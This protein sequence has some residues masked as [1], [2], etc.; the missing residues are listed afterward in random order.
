MKKEQDDAKQTAALRQSKE[1]I[2][3]LM[4]LLVGYLNIGL[5]IRYLILHQPD[6]E[7][8]Q[9]NYQLFFKNSLKL[10]GKYLQND[11]ALTRRFSNLLK[12]SDLDITAREKRNPKEVRERFLSLLERE[13]E[14]VID[15][16]IVI[17]SEAVRRRPSVTKGR[18]NGMPPGYG[19]QRNTGFTSPNQ[20]TRD[21]RP[22]SAMYGRLERPSSAKQMFPPPDARMNHTQAF[23]HTT[24]GGLNSYDE[25]F[26]GEDVYDPGE[27]M[28]TTPMGDSEG[29]LLSTNNTRHRKLR[30]NQVLSNNSRVA[31]FPT[32]EEFID[33]VEMQRKQQEL[34]SALLDIKQQNDQMQRHYKERENEVAALKSQLGKLQSQIESQAQLKPATSPPK[35]DKFGWPTPETGSSQAQKPNHVATAQA[36]PPQ[37]R[38][39]SMKPHLEPPQPSKAAT[40][41]SQDGEFDPDASPSRR[42]SNNQ[43]KLD[44][45]SISQDEEGRP[46]SKTPTPDVARERQLLNRNQPKL[47]KQSFQ[48][49]LDSEKGQSEGSNGGLAT[50]SQPKRATE[51][52]QTTSIKPVEVEEVK[53]KKKEESGRHGEKMQVQQDAKGILTHVWETLPFLDKAVLSQKVICDEIEYLVEAELTTQAKVP[54]IMLK[55]TQTAGKGRPI[56]GET[57]PFGEVKDIIQEFELKDVLPS[58]I[59]AKSFPSCVPFLQYYLMPFIGV[60]KFKGSSS[61]G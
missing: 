13:P 59:A 29:R 45:S 11:H 43:L 10:C 28:T 32:Q 20:Q 57:I 4:I 31:P 33:K 30:Y 9:T 27:R 6:I 16:S 24:E 44:L 42:I 61:Y 55:A 48:S 19:F 46:K 47:G 41:S 23:V 25:G 49:V 40:R 35:Q 39:M 56:E 1:F 12:E 17:H 7:L 14:D 53:P 3:L 2:D 60:L 38:R 58:S 37:D 21:A 22:R 8:R 51:K 15:E 50:G 36:Q 54:V 52:Q 5:S 34:E 18:V 26:I